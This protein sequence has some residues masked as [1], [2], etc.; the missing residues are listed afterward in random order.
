MVRIPNILLLKL[1]V[2]L[3]PLVLSAN[4]YRETV[5]IKTSVIFN[6]RCAKCHEGECSGR[7]S[8][9]SGDQAARSHIRRYAEENSSSDKEI[10]AFYA[11]LN[12]MKKKCTILMPHK[13]DKNKLKELSRFALSSYKGYFIPLGRLEKG[14]Y[15]L[16]II[17]KEENRYNLEILSE[18]LNPI[19]NIA[20]GAG[21]K[22][23]IDF[24]IE[25][26]IDTF[27][28]IRS[29]QAL[30]IEKLKIDKR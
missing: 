7:L 18:H 23:N 21:K 2:L 12:H 4:E 25:K 3:F 30:H 19:V 14:A 6:I 27:L 1:S 26:P 28:R 11:L 9:D 15:T 17:T 22:K 5:S 10:K 8:F 29:R 24:T 20:V 13:D 16:S